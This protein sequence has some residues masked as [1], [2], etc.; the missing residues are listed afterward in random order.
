M[1]QTFSNCIREARHNKGYS[2]RDLAALVKVDY[3]YLSKLENNRTEY[4]PSE[5]IIKL[6]AHHLEL[7]TQELIYQAGRITAEDAKVVGELAKTY[8]KQLPVLLRLIRDNPELNRKFF[9]KQHT[10]KVN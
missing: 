3:T 5:E 4:A 2:Q 10:P 8:Q 1:N 7:D 6:L 9:G